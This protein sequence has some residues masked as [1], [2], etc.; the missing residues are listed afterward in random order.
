MCLFP[1]VSNIYAQWEAAQKV[2]SAQAEALSLDPQLKA[3]LLEQARAYNDM[4]AGLT[5]SLSPQD[6]W[7]Y[8][9]QLQTDIYPSMAWIEIPK[10]AI[11]VNVYHGV[12]EEAL[13]AG[14]GHQSESS[15]PVGGQRSK[16]VLSGHSG[17]RRVRIFDGIRALEAGDVFAIHTLGDVYAYRVY[18]WKIVDPSEVNLAPEDGDIVYLVTCT[19]SPDAFNPKGRIGINDKR[20]VVMAKRC[21]YVEAEFT[22]VKPDVSVYINDNYLPAILS[23]L[24]FMVLAMAAALRRIMKKR[25]LSKHKR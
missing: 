5:P 17:L 2:E 9:R 11:K 24:I 16:V 22:D 6:I 3:E 14:V 12:D 23:T 21:P 1:F 8:E 4:N 25:D 13:S 18:D 15:L 20:L 7:P 19:T 10:A